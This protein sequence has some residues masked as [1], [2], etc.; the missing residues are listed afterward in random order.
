M[1]IEGIA[2]LIWI[3]SPFI[4]VGVLVFA[5]V[6][7]GFIYVIHEERRYRKEINSKRK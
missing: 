7:G 6:I 3:L 2:I 5:V 4:L 1:T